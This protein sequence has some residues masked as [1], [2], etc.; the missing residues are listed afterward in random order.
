MMMSTI[1]EDGKRAV[2]YLRV[3][4]EEQVENYS[5]NTQEDI[6]RKEADKRGYQIVDVFSEEGKSAKTIS[7]RT[8]L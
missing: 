5:L 7:G 8:V 6:C 3:S 1:R 2:I 4:S